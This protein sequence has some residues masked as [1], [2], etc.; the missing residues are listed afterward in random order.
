MDRTAYESRLRN[1][2]SWAG[3]LWSTLESVLP[4]AAAELGPPGDETLQ[5]A[6]NAAEALHA[7]AEG[8]ADVMGAYDLLLEAAE[9]SPR[10][11]NF[12]QR[13]GTESAA[14]SRRVTRTKDPIRRSAEPSTRGWRPSSISTRAGSSGRSMAR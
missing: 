9:R 11:G 1:L 6:R 12:F 10:Y 8:L 5:D 13:L 3:H 7:V 14:P 2:H 4:Q